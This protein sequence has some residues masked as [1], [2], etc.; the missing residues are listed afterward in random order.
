MLNV[1]TKDAQKWET[2]TLLL[3]QQT[4]PHSRNK[5]VQGMKYRR[6]N[7]GTGEVVELEFHENHHQC[8]A[9]HNI[10]PRDVVKQIAELTV[11]AWNLGSGGSYT[12]ELVGEVEDATS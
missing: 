9:M 2:D 3:H 4:R 10:Q 5:E 12:Y 6:T 8:F 11:M 1:D 7:V